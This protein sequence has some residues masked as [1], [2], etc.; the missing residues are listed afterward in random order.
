MTPAPS[1]T[2][3]ASLRVAAKLGLHARPSTAV[4]R[5]VAKFASRVSLS[6]NGATADG[7]SIIELMTLNVPGGAEIAVE[8]TGS[9][10]PALIEALRGLL[11]ETVKF[12]G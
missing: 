8:A 12:D 1:V 9:D 10:A 2:I 7:R 3:R 4:A 11:E 5:L 6:W